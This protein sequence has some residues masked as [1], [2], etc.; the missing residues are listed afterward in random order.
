MGYKCVTEPVHTILPARPKGDLAVSGDD[1]VGDLVRDVFGLHR[2][3]GGS[4]IEP[5]WSPAQG[6]LGGQA[7]GTISP[8][9]LGGVQGVVN[10]RIVNHRWRCWLASRLDALRARGRSPAQSLIRLEGKIR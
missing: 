5:S 6:S 8:P 7:S 2:R 9:V 3:L 4:V 10:P 1:G